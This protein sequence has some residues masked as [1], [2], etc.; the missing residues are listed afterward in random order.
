[1]PDI[2]QYA[3]EGFSYAVVIYLL[4]ERREVLNAVKETLNSLKES[5]NELITIVKERVK[6]EEEGK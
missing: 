4:W 1:M 3:R 6:S 5:I 2:T